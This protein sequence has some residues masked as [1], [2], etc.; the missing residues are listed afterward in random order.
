VLYVLLIADTFTFFYANKIMKTKI[1]AASLNN[2]LNEAYSLSEK[3]ITSFI[4]NQKVIA[5]SDEHLDL[6]NS[7]KINLD[8]LV[9][10][11]AIINDEIEENFPNS[12]KE[13][14]SLKKSLQALYMSLNSF[15]KSLKRYN[16]LKSHLQKVLKI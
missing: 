3:Y 16:L 6:I 5:G 13:I 14:E 8:K 12:L 11:L 1:S 2:H 7:T 4:P 10:A 15:L 9:K